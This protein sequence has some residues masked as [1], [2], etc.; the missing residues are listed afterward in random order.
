MKDGGNRKVYAKMV[1]KFVEV[2]KVKEY[3]SKGIPMKTCNKA[4]INRVWA[5]YSES[6]TKQS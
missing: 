1:E 4:K 2:L 3:E 6:D 5:T